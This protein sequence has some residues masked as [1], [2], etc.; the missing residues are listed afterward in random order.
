LCLR[1]CG[2]RGCPRALDR[3]PRRLPSMLFV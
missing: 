3:R 2:S 1:R